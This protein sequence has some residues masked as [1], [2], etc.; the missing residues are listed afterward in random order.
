M[1]RGK[2]GER[3]EVH[4][5]GEGCDI[6]FGGDEDGREEGLDGPDGDEDGF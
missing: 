1:G 6:D 2:W 4:V 3:G 5:D